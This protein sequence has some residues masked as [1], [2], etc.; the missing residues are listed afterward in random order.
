SRRYD[1]A[2][3]S[4]LLGA[5]LVDDEELARALVR[6]LLAAHPDIRILAECANGFE[7]V[8]VVAETKPDLLFL[9]V[10]MP[11][12]DGLEVLELIER[13]AAG[14]PAVIFVTAYDQYALKAFD[15]NAVDDLLKPFD[16]ARF[17]TSL[18]RARPRPAP[19]PAPPHAARLRRRAGPRSSRSARRPSFPCRREGRCHGDGPPRFEDRLRESRGRLR[20]P[21]CGRTK[22]S[23]EPDAREPRGGASEGAVREDPPVLSVEP[24]PPRAPRALHDGRADGRADRWRQTSGEPDGSAT[25]ARPPRSVTLDRRGDA[26]LEFLRELAFRKNAE[27]EKRDAALS[28]REGDPA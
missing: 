19:P 13:D 17:A 23:E 5:V 27:R 8:K 16:R 14:R 28:P 12:L 7:A 9:D 22:P 20:P 24:R 10:Q 6:Q 18:P 3:P 26:A 15:A 1:C 11:Q 25:P 2:V 4:P 21:P